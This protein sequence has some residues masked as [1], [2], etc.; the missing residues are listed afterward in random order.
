M[1]SND[2]VSQFEFS[3]K[4]RSVEFD[5]EP[6]QEAI[7]NLEQDRI[8]SN[9][10]IKI[11]GVLQ[12]IRR[13]YDNYKRGGFKTSGPDYVG[14]LTL[15]AMIVYSYYRSNYLVKDVYPE[16]NNLF[17]KALTGW[18]LSLNTSRKYDGKIDELGIF[19]VAMS[20]NCLSGKELLTV[21]KETETESFD[22]D[23]SASDYLRRVAS[24][25][26]GQFNSE[27]TLYGDYVNKSFPLS[28]SHREIFQSLLI[29]LSYSNLTDCPNNLYSSL[30]N[31]LKN[32]QFLYLY[33]YRYVGT[34][35]ERKGLWFST[36]EHITL[37]RHHLDSDCS[38]STEFISKLLYSIK[39]YHATF[40][41]DD[42]EISKC[43]IGSMDSSMDYPAISRLRDIAT[44][45]LLS[46]IDNLLITKLT[47]KFDS[48]LYR[49]LLVDNV[50]LITQNDTLFVTYVQ[51]VDENKGDSVTTDTDGFEVVRNYELLNFVSGI[52]YSETRTMMDP[53]IINNLTNLNLYQRWLISPE[54]FNYDDFK[55]DWIQLSNN[56]FVL[57][58]L[59]KSKKLR[60]FILEELRTRPDAELGEKYIKMIT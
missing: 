18:L 30:F 1:S 17:K 42:F 33:D 21:F 55:I 13:I 50:P 28:S 53:I 5:S 39:K 43:I 41:V 8:L 29:N 19:H 46:K 34:L 40:R 60:D 49:Q 48:N 4:I 27:N 25:Y 12:N 32:Q 44:E 3:S 37:L 47:E 22:I 10:H 6:V 58:H 11:D 57:K 35:F 24:N 52:L 59:G 15:E 54:D 38:N 2:R 7:L 26:F 16:Y 45:S 51:Y 36:D 31:F 23:Q 9:A 14:Q 56:T 20:V